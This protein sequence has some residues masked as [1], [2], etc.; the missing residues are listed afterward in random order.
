MWAKNAEAGE[1]LACY[2]DDDLDAISDPGSRCGYDDE[3]LDAVSAAL[4]KRN[5]TL[6]ADDVGL[7]AAEIE[8]P[9]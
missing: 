5:M 8:R 2:E 1:Y 4:R 9:L 3:T 6:V 7:C